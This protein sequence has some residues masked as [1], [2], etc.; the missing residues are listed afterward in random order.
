M[1]GLSLIVRLRERHAPR[2]LSAR[3][4][5]GD[6][7]RGNGFYELVDTV[8][9]DGDGVAEII[10]IHHNYEFHEFVVLRRDAARYGIAFRGPS[11]GC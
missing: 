5:E 10:A 1:V 7:D 4:S 9:V 11:Y 3:M 2:V 8:D 6:L